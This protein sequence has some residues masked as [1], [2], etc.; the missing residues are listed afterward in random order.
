MSLMMSKPR[1]LITDFNSGNKKKHKEAAQVSRKV[2]DNNDRQGPDRGLT[3]INFRGAMLESSY[4]FF[5]A[6][7]SKSLHAWADSPCLNFAGFRP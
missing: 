7:F 3:I 4:E 2:G 1:P 6:S 5:C